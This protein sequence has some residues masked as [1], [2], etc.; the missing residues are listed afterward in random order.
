MESECAA[1]CDF[2]TFWKAVT[3]HQLLN[4]QRNPKSEHQADQVVASI[5]GSALRGTSEAA[6]VYRANFM[7]IFLPQ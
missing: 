3:N 2:V 4:L 6:A 7:N 1:D 5:T